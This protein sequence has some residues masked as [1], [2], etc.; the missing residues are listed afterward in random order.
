MIGSYVTEKKAIYDMEP[1][2][3]TIVLQT[4]SK[5]GLLGYIVELESDSKL[6]WDIETDN[7]YAR[8]HDHLKPKTKYFW[9]QQSNTAFEESNED[10]GNTLKDFFG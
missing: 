5:D 3:G 10:L 8:Y 7:L 4:E 1:R 6:C 2:E 9:V